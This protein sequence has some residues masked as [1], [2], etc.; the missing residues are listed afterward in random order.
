MGSVARLFGTDYLSRAGGGARQTNRHGGGGMEGAGWLPPPAGGGDSAV[1]ERL[2]RQP[3]PMD[4]LPNFRAHDCR[5]NPRRQTGQRTWMAEMKRLVGDAGALV[6]FITAPL[7][8]PRGEGGSAR[9]RPA[10]EE[11]QKPSAWRSTPRASCSGTIS[12]GGAE[13]CRRA[14]PPP[15][16]PTRW[17]RHLRADREARYDRCGPAP[18]PPAQGNGVA[19]IGFIAEA[20][21]CQVHRQTAACVSTPA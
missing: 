14:L 1:V 18:W 11:N 6:V 16:R 17:S 15:R 9:R 21:N 12:H 7:P 4:S 19:K 2:L 5:R 13:I 20:N 3:G 10:H 8:H